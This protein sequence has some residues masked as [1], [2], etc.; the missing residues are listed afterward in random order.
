MKC[1]VRYSDLRDEEQLVSDAR[2]GLEEVVHVLGEGVGLGDSTAEGH[3]D[4][5]AADQGA[6][7]VRRGVVTAS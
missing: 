4:G 5:N 1:L 2:L 6:V 7:T 3:E